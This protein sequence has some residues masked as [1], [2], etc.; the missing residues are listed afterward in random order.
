MCKSAL[1]LPFKLTCAVFL[2]FVG[3]WSQQVWG[4]VWGLCVVCLPYLAGIL[5]V[6][7]TD[8]NLMYKRWV[9]LA[10]LTIE[11]QLHTQLARP[12]AMVHGWNV[13]L[14]MCKYLLCVY[15]CYVYIITIS[16]VVN[17]RGSGTNLAKSLV[18]SFKIDFSKTR[19]VTVEVIISQEGQKGASLFCKFLL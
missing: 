15:M 10:F 2:I 8:G 12:E 7:V 1:L 5:D 16:S 4:F 11:H 14:D 19:P 17:L 18:Y 9:T 3:F 13:V 6:V